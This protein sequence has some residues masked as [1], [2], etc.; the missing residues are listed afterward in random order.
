MYALF[1]GLQACGRIRGAALSVVPNPNDRHLEIWPETPFL[2]GCCERP[3]CG[4]EDHSPQQAATLKR[5]PV[6]TGVG[7]GGEQGE[8]RVRIAGQDE[9][10]GQQGQVGHG[11]GQ[12]KLESGL[13]ATEVPGLS[14]PQLDQS[15]QPVLG[16]HP[17]LAILVIGWTLL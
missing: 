5:S 8:S 12:V 1:R 4:Q 9:F 10:V 16:H 11:C 3:C 7:A 17:P 13:G 6:S 2:L 14:Y 15:G